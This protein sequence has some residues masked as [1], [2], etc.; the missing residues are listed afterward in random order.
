MRFR[1]G[2]RR[3]TAAISVIV[4][5]LGAG[6]SGCA[7]DAPAGRARAVTGTEIWRAGDQFVRLEPPRARAG[8][9]PPPNAHPMA[10]TAD[11]IANAFAL[12]R[13]RLAPDESP[14][15]LF[16]PD[17]LETLARPLSAGLARARPDQD[18][19]FAIERYDQGIFGFTDTRVISGRVFY[20]GGWLHLIL[21]SVLA[22]AAVDEDVDLDPYEP[23]GRDFIV[24]P[25]VT[26]EAPPGA[27][28]YR[29][30]WI[31]HAHWLLFEPQALGGRPPLPPGPPGPPP[32]Y[33]PQGYPPQAYPPQGYPPPGYPPQGYPPQAYPPQGYPPQGYPPQ[34]NLPPGYPPQG[35]P[36]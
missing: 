22:D 15:R 17:S 24:A 10:I 18:V 36:P 25:E 11:Q 30:P 35:Y 12:V 9:G 16:T 31:D 19:T 33:P 7:G 14:Q 4:L 28:V 6:L 21:G 26:L 8:G 27:A 2:L 23:G 5:A 3:R 29:A 32:G 20:G 1:R 13:A 34:G